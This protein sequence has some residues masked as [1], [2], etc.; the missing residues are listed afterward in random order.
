MKEIIKKNNQKT[1]TTTTQLY[2]INFYFRMQRHPSSMYFIAIKF[3]DM[4]K[5]F[6][7]KQSP[8]TTIK[9]CQTKQNDLFVML[10]WFS[11]LLLMSNWPYHQN[12][13]PHYVKPLLAFKGL[14]NR[15]SPVFHVHNKWFRFGADSL[16]LELS[17]ESSVLQYHPLCINSNNIHNN[18]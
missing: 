15:N 3:P 4:H 1:H 6:S 5:L 14:G 17:K 13:T 11:V 7:R 12:I 9:S 16:F 8:K 18:H 10:F 2:K